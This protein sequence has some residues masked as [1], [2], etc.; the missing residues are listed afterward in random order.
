[1]S[2][3]RH[4]EHNASGRDFAVGDIHGH[5]S[6]LQAALDAVAFDP[7][8]DRLFSVGDLVDRGPESA[9][10]LEWLEKPWFMAVQGNHEELA[11]EYALTGRVRDLVAYMACGSGWFLALS[12]DEQRSFAARF[13]GLP[14]AI[15]VET[16]AGL[17]GLVHADCPLSSWDELRSVLG[18]RRDSR[19]G[20][21][22]THCLWARE[23]IRTGDERPVTGVRAVVVGHTRVRQP[24]VLGNVHHIDT[25][26]WHPDG[27]GY[28]TLLE[29]DSLKSR[30]PRIARAPA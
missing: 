12:R 14:I 25:G 5:F 18:G 16:R 23:R 10:A 9:K 22:K 17:V 8:L 28:F 7:A 13:M 30:T 6:E 20:P 29:L 24:L 15:E 27:T 4:F 3:I 19:F 2:Q 26:I 21:V 1:M 11:I